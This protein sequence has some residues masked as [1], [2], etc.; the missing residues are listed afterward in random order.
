[1]LGSGGS[2]RLGLADVDKIDIKFC[3]YA[4]I[5]IEVRYNSVLNTMH[6]IHIGVSA[7]HDIVGFLAYY[8][9]GGGGG[10][11]LEKRYDAHPPSWLVVLAGQ[12]KGSKN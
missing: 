1:M 7:I 12:Q 2:C 4:C 6:L 9:G 11:I 5:F 3:V 8:T 10:G